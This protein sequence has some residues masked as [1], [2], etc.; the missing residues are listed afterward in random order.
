MS[1]RCLLLLL[2]A[3]I[4][5]GATVPA[6]AQDKITYADHV[7]PLIEQHCAN[8][9][10][11]DKKKGDLVLTSY[12]EVLKGGGSGPGVVS[13]NLDASR[14]WKSITHAEDPA[15][16]PKKPKLAEKDLDVFRK[17]I[18]GGLLETSG[19]KAVAAA[20]P[21]VDLTLKVS[22]IGKPDGPPPMPGD[23]LPLDPVLH[24]P[25]AGVIH[26]LAASPWAP[27]V[28][29]AGQKQI[30]LYHTTNLALL[31]IL[32]FPEGQPIDVK[33]SRSGKLLLAA[34]GHGAKSGRVLLWNI[35]TGE[36]VA[37]LGEE[38]D[39]VLAA[40][41]SPDQSRVA[42]G[43]PSRLV[44]IH[45]TRTGEVEHRMKKHTDWVT[46]VAF[47]P[48]GEFLAT[49][50]RNGGVVLWDADNG[51]ELFTTVGHKGAIT[52]L[53][54]RDDSRLVASSSEDGSV[55]L[56]ETTEGRQART[57]VAHASG[58]LGVA[59]S[60]DGRFVTCGRDGVVT[61]WTGENVRSKNLPF[62]GEMTLRCAFSH[63]GNRVIAADFAGR[64]GVWEVASGKLAGELDANPPPL[65]EQLAA[66]ERRLAE[67]QAGRPP[68]KSAEQTA[69]ESTL[70]KLKAELDAAQ[71][72]A[73]KARAD[74][75]AKAADVVRLKELSTSTAPPAGTDAK[76]AAART[77][78]ETARPVHTNTTVAL[79]EKTRALAAA[80]SKLGLAPAPSDPAASLAEARAT[81][82]RLRNAQ[83][84]GTFFRA[85][86]ALATKKTD[87]ASRQADVVTR[88][89]AIR[90]LTAD[91]DAA[92]EATAKGRLKA[93]L[94]SAQAELKSAEAGVKKA[95]SEV[96]AAQAQVD[97]LA[98]AAQHSKR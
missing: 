74:F 49:G 31:G 33:F 30:L 97:T 93:E 17:W 15:M 87:L 9:H 62:H 27:V 3:G 78:R 82:E 71:A 11:P 52:G 67:L 76:L 39:A 28:A 84:R 88:Q 73:D 4:A 92:K 20:K 38:F 46:A 86:E 16:P 81:V 12:N 77:A 54:W 59:Y 69:A 6:R 55:K 91:L 98:G 61:A 56:W 35:E 19:S 75:L 40:D 85:R 34:G 60:H 37:T 42:L 51:Q 29:I 24:T 89:E 5:A 41:L 96:A 14:V 44:K 90:K 10:N 8:C 7:L 48:N 66:A 1:R 53:S 79:A 13:G 2:A 65:A 25:R 64:V 83:G 63:D 47:S 70:A 72:A 50:D 45:A 26:G 21:S 95:Q 32:P 94:K 58:V 22:N 43:G 68:A 36:R 57:W 80:Q 23:S 18:A